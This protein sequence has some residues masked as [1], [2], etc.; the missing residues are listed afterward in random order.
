MTRSLLLTL[1]MLYAACIQQS[2]AQIIPDSSFSQDGYIL[3]IRQNDLFSPITKLMELPDGSVLIPGFFGDRFILRKYDAAGN[4][5][6]TFGTNG[7]ATMPALNNHLSTICDIDVTSDNKIWVLTEYINWSAQLSDSDKAYIAIMSF[8]EDGSANNTFNGSGYLIDQPMQDYY[9]HPNTMAIDKGGNKAAIYIGSWAYE[10]G[11]NICSAGFGQ[12]CISKYNTDG[13]RETGFNTTG[14]LQGNASIINQAPT[15]APLAIIYDLQVMN[16]GNIVAAGSM[17]NLDSSFF[18]LRLLPNGQWDNTFGINGRHIHKV[19]FE[20]PTNDMTNSRVLSDGSAVFYTS[21][22]YG[23]DSTVVNIAKSD[24]T[25]HAMNSF[26]S[27][28]KIISG[29]GCQQ[30]PVLIF[31]SDQSFLMAYYKQYPSQSDQKIEFAHF[32]Q[33]GVQDMSFGVNGICRTHPRNPDNYLNVSQVIDG[34]W[35][36]NET[37]IY[38]AT[39]NW[40]QGSVWPGSGLFKFIWPGSPPAPTSIQNVTSNVHYSVYPNPL[41]PGNYLTVESDKEIKSLK[42]YSV[43]GNLIYIKTQFKDKKKAILQI[44]QNL[45]AGVYYLFSNEEKISAVIIK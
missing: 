17:F 18:S 10:N 6:T 42:L 43:Q 4:I 9:Y 36:G 44:P 34:I 39:Q 38:L 16:S 32:N 31:K 29:Y 8:N 25:G 12:W 15:T 23:N 35:T 5:V 41:Q 30:Y 33:N 28:G 26:G 37:G 13:T 24:N 22:R 11:H 2:T 27:N 14:F 7:E 3:D 20:V 1:L 40:P 45:S 21:Y 19:D